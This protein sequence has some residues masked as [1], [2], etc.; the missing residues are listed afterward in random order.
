MDEYLGFS[1]FSVLKTLLQV[2]SLHIYLCIGKLF[3]KY[4]FPKEK[5][6]GQRI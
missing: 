6:L 1:D 3:L 4:R 5:F 2:T